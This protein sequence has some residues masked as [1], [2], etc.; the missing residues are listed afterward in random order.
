MFKK[1]KEDDK[2][3]G[4]KLGGIVSKGGDGPE[5]RE[6]CG[7]AERKGSNKRGHDSYIVIV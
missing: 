3:N 6:E 2:E 1:K 5:E 7:E 4:Q